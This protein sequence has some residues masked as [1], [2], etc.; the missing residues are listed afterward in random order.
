MRCVL[1]LSPAPFCRVLT[2]LE[3]PRRQ[4]RAVGAS[5]GEHMTRMTI[6]ALLAATAAPLCSLAH[7]VDIRTPLVCTLDAAG[8]GAFAV[9]NT[10]GHA[11]KTD[12]LINADV[13][14][15]K[16]GMPGTISLCFPLTADLKPGAPATHSTP[17]ESGAVPQFCSAFVS[18]AHPSVVH[19]PDGGSETDCDP[20]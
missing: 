18:S 3:F 16:P 15:Q 6:F 19:T 20:H 10:T 13:H 7:A 17:L 8:H 1:S 14:W 11:L 5:W 9:K 2:L 4:T 12:T